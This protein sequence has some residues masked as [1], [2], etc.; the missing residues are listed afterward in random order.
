[1]YT[2]D[3]DKKIQED[4]IA[5]VKTSLSR[6]SQFTSHTADKFSIEDCVYLAKRLQLHHCISDE[7]VKKESFEYLLVDCFNRRGIN[8]MRNLNPT[9]PGQ[10][11]IIDGKN[12]SCKTESSAKIKRDFI[13]ITKFMECAWQK[14]FNSKEDYLDHA[15]PK[16]LDH[17]S[18]YSTI[19]TMRYFQDGGYEIVE[20]PKSILEQ[21]KYADV[22][23]MGE[24]TARRKGITIYTESSRKGMKVIFDG[25]DDKI[26][27]GSIPVS[28]CIRHVTFLS[29][30]HTVK[31]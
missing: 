26:K 30:N 22:N 13:N 10:D 21:I 25:S 11:V 31:K 29:G 3:I 4:I 2:P 19:M 6:K 24:F 23:Q 7:P 28:Q 8:A 17:L 16:I 14:D 18:K 5:T 1:M 9:F 27:I 20:I 12:W 15:V